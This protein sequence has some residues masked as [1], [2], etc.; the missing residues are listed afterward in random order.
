MTEDEKQIYYRDARLNGEYDKIW[1]SV[2]KCCFCDKA[3]NEQY[4]VLEE[5][6]M[7]LR[8]PQ[9]AYIDGHLL[10]VPRRHVRSMKDLT[11][12]EWEAARRLMYVAKKM[13]REI[14]GIK[15]VQFVQKDGASAQATVPDHIHWHVVPFDAPDL[16]VWNYR[17]LKN[18]PAENAALF[19]AR[20]EKMEKLSR[21]FEE[22]YGG[23]GGGG[24]GSS[25]GDLGAEEEA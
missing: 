8:V 16:S 5:D 10:I 22:K 24:D 2:G 14:H 18:T 21:R 13:I 25:A 20:K 4:V 1:Q 9:Y 6:G 11:S 7:M 19:E 3:E 23:G 12:R 17:R 15:G